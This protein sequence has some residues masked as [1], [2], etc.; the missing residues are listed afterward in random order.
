MI[1]E[2]DYA[3]Y[4]LESRES[5]KMENNWRIFFRFYMINIHGNAWESARYNFLKAIELNESRAAVGLHNSFIIRYEEKNLGEDWIISRTFSTKWNWK[6]L[7]PSRQNNVHFS[8]EISI[9]S[10]WNFAALNLRRDS[11][12]IDSLQTESWIVHWSITVLFV[13]HAHP[14]K[15]FFRKKNSNERTFQH[16]PI[17]K[18]R[19]KYLITVYQCYQ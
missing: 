12:C 16:S 10:K 18:S 3:S 6:S 15:Y 19:N 2:R 17:Y 9:V 8:R 13:D 11:I 4:N 14:K 1:E 5:T 7:N